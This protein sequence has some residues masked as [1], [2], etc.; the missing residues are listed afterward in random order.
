MKT[1]VE[2][3]LRQT[4]HYE[5]DV[6]DEDEKNLRNAFALYRTMNWSGRGYSKLSMEK[7]L[8]FAGEYMGIKYEKTIKQNTD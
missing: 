6:N 7:F 5:L 2:V 1:W 8:S 4:T 3:G